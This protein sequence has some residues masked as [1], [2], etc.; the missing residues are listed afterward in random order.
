MRNQTDCKWEQK[1]KQVLPFVSWQRK[2]SFDE[3]IDRG[4]GMMLIRI[5]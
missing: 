1:G 2:I 4:S 5:N 3:H